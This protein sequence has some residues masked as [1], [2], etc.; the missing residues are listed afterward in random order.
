[1]KKRVAEWICARGTASGFSGLS[2]AASAVG[3][4]DGCR[5]VRRKG[6]KR[7]AL[8]RKLKE[9]FRS[10]ISQSVTRVIGQINPILRGWVHY[11]AWGHSSRFSIRVHAAFDTGPPRPL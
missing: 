8:L 1:M 10:L 7:T 9:I 3:G 11:F 5:C 6:K 4:G 2:S